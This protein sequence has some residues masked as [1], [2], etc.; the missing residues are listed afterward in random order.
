MATRLG[1]GDVTRSERVRQHT[2]FSPTHTD[3]CCGLNTPD[4]SADRHSGPSLTG[5]HGSAARATPQLRHIF[6]VGGLPG[7]LLD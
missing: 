3:P 2:V 1:F 4:R 7:P 5:S 6:G